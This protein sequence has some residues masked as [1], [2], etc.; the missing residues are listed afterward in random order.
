MVWKCVWAAIMVWSS[1]NIGHTVWSYHERMTKELKDIMMAVSMI[2]G[3]LKYAYSPLSEVFSNASSRTDGVIAAWFMWLAEKTGENSMDSF[4][5]I[6]KESM[7]LLEKHSRLNEK[8]LAQII[9]LGRILGYLDVE[10]QL[11]GLSLW[12]KRIQFEY[13]FQRDRSVNMKK[14]AHSLGIL[15]GLFLVIIM[16]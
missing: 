3:E 16:L 7:D 8:Q 13:E 5:S 1:Y 12:E 2:K 6:W 10:A 14:T 9:E 15:G 4:L 11:A